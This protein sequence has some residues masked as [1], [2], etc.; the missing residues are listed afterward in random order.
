MSILRAG[1]VAEVLRCLEWEGRRKASVIGVMSTL[2]AVDED[3]GAAVPVEAQV[4]ALRICA[5]LHQWAVLLDMEA[6]LPVEV[7]ALPDV[8]RLRELAVTQGQ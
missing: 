4:L 7:R 5:E 1:Q 3:L 8:Q 2:R 6:T